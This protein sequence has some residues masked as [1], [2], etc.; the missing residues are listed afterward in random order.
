M[1]F[2]G[3]AGKGCQRFVSLSSLLILSR[4]QRSSR[5]IVIYD[6]DNLKKG[7]MSDQLRELLLNIAGNNKWSGEHTK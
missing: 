4:T 3:S 6:Y 7:V 1:V 5:T 2:E